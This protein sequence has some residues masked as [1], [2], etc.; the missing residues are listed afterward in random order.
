M[1]I[2]SSIEVLDLSSNIISDLEAFHN[3]TATTPHVLAKLR[4]VNLSNNQF[5]N[6][7]ALL[8]LANAAKGIV[9]LDLSGNPL[10]HTLNYLF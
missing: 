10:V 4:I 1:H 2:F 5:P 7:R 3:H 8:P 9:E 6:V